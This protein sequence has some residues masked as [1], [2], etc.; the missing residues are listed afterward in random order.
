MRTLLGWLL[1]LVGRLAL[2]EQVQEFLGVLD[3]LGLGRAMSTI[4]VV[5]NTNIIIIWNNISNNP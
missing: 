5:V 3:F 1:G 4:V 2:L